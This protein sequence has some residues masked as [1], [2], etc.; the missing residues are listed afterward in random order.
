MTRGHRVTKELKMGPVDI[1][2]SISCNNDMWLRE[3]NN[4]FGFC[5]VREVFRV[6]AF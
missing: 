1:K 6:L 5:F 2:Q 4:A 3:L